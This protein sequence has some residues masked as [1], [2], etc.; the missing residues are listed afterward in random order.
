MPVNDALYQSPGDFA[1]NASNPI[2]FQ[3]T[4]QLTANS[5]SDPT[6][7]KPVNGGLNTI[8][9]FLD[10]SGLYGSSLED[11][12]R[13]R[14]TGCLMKTALDS[15]GNEYPPRKAAIPTEYDLGFY[16]AR[17][18][19]IF[20]SLF[21]T[22]FLREH[23]LYCT[24]LKTANPTMDDTTAFEKTRAYVIGLLQHITFTEY[25]ASVVGTTPP[26][27]K[28]CYLVFTMQS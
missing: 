24:Q 18:G 15:L 12:T 19:D 26:V 17:S 10:Q 1:F 4:P 2:P 23:N 21:S 20:T 22:L 13:L 3:S 11:V 16:S 28:A 9:G 14:G 7:N 5:S 6:K 8:T 25:L 27:R